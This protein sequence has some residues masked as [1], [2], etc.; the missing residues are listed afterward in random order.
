MSVST[1][2]EHGIQRVRNNLT[3]LHRCF[4][5]ARERLGSYNS[6]A[7]VTGTGLAP[8]IGEFGGNRRA[9]PYSLPG[10]TRGR[11]GKPDSK[12][13]TKDVLILD[14]GTDRAPSRRER[15]QYNPGSEVG[16]SH[17]RTARESNF[18]V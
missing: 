14:F 9:G 10:I 17:N 6:T 11:A 3:E 1:E 8:G 5:T 2:G 16:E 13:V 7:T 4:L 18:R 15:A 12:L